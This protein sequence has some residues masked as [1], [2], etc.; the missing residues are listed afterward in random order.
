MEIIEFRA[1]QTSVLALAGAL[2][3]SSAPAL[4]VQAIGLCD[5]GNRAILIDLTEVPYLTSAAFRAFIAI[6]KR[7]EPAGVVM[8]LCGLND[9][10]RDLFEASG[11]MGVFRI[12]PD[13]AS[14][15]AAI[16]QPAAP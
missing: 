4:S 7:A 13:R 14:A 12:Y 10:L 5:G 3:T 11:L 8:A 6:R 9:L 1:G 2:D 16:D 15:V